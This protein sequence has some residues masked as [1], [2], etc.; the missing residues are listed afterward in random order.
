M[1]CEFKEKTEWY[2]KNFTKIMEV[3]EHI[4]NCEECKKLLDSSSEKI[5]LPKLAK[6]DE[7]TDL[8]NK[9]LKRN[10]GIKRIFIFSIIGIVMGFLSFYYR[11]QNFIVSKI[12]IAIPYKIMEMVLLYIRP[13]VNML[14]GYNYWG[15]MIFMR[16]PV[17]NH[18]TER[19]I[20]CLIGG[21]IYGSI[22]YITGD[23]NIFT[24]KKFVIFVSKWVGVTAICIALIFGTYYYG[25]NKSYQLEDISGFMIST[26]SD[27][28][29]YDG[30]IGVYK[31]QYSEKYEI[32]TGGLK[33]RKKTEHLPNYQYD[34]LMP[35]TIFGKWYIEISA[36]LD[37]QNNLIYIDNGEVFEVPK[38]FVDTCINIEN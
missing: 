25:L 33:E 29:S 21:C 38:S 34:N 30:S 28:T 37:T 11:E 31:D 7:N 1:S 18:I 32:L 6:L 12:I 24:L 35:I 16:F 27:G 2:C 9:V 36:M 22:G 19:V 13:E 14:T 17:L 20:P 23:K 4:S 10:R 8:L 15:D 3:E 5:D 26:S